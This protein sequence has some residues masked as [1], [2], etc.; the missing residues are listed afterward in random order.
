MIK[1]Y[2]WK[3]IG[4][5]NRGLTPSVIPFDGSFFNKRLRAYNL[6]FQVSLNKILL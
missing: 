6:I 3:C 2:F 5:T 4:D 1:L